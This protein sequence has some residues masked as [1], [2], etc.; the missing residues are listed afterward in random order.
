[1]KPEL[2]GPVPLFPLPEVVFFPGT[3]L[4]LHVFEPRY[5]AM[6]EDLLS[7]EDRL[8]AMALLE[9]GWQEDYHGNPPIHAV[10]TVGR[11]IRAERLED[12]RF[13]LQLAGLARARVLEEVHGKAYRL[14]RLEVLPDVPVDPEVGIPLR[15]HLLRTLASV[16]GEEGE[17]DAPTVLLDPSVSLG[18]LCDKLAALLPLEPEEKQQLLAERDPVTRSQQLLGLLRGLRGQVVVHR[19]ERGLPG[20]S[21]N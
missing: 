18:S 5:R 4:P 2:Q 6:A 11:V 19:P 12:G 15:N 10:V 16:V 3:I 9:E 21:A 17:G 20:F 1:M 14:G 7:G 8:M 13:L